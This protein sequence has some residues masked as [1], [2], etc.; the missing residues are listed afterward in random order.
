MAAGS[1]YVYCIQ[2]S[3]DVWRNKTLTDWIFRSYEVYC[4]PRLKLLPLASPREI[5]GVL[6]NNKLAS[7]LILVSKCILLLG[8]IGRIEVNTYS[9]HH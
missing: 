6:G 5:V 8:Y 7:I 3:Y 2:I 4:S 1:V 9:W